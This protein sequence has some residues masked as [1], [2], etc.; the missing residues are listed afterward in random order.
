MFLPHYDWIS[1][2]EDKILVNF[3]CHFENLSQ[4]FDCVCNQINKNTK[5]PHFKATK[6]GNYR[7]YYE[8]DTREI[9]A[10]WFAKDIQNFDYHF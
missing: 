6:R 9:V 1:D 4:D 7:D 2:Q 8:A 3:I 10:S 5:L